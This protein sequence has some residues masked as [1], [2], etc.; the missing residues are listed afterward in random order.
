MKQNTTP[1]FL[2]TRLNNGFQIFINVENTK[3]IDFYN[4]VISRGESVKLLVLINIT[5]SDGGYNTL[6]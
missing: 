1:K 4:P 5:I 3:K 6:S 2:Q